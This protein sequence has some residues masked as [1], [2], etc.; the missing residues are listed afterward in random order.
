MTPPKTA[1]LRAPKQTAGVRLIRRGKGFSDE[2]DRVTARDGLAG[3]DGLVAGLAHEINTP[4]GVGI[5]ASTNLEE[6]VRAFSSEMREGKLSD[7]KREDYLADIG[8]LSALISR[9]LLRAADLVRNFKLVSSNQIHLDSREFAVAEF[10]NDVILSLSPR[11][12][13]GSHRVTVECDERLRVVAGTGAFSQILTNLILNAVV[14]GF[15]DKSGGEIKIAVSG[16]RDRLCLVVED[17]GVG[18][19]QETLDRMFDPYFTTARSQGGTG[20]GLF[21]VHNVVTRQFAGTL[22]C[23]SAFGEGTRFTINLNLRES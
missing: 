1:F 13:S 18:M 8:E 22:D 6:L 7:E 10:V 17:D 14:H 16:D 21:I 9:N 2:S 23:A 4:L 20:L 15:R 19:D 11:L 3:L 5:T 12:E